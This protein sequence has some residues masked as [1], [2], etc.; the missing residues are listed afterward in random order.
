MHYLSFYCTPKRT[1]LITS[2]KRF[3]LMKRSGMF[4]SI[5]LFLTVSLPSRADIPLVHLSS[6][7]GLSNNSVWCCLQDR[8]GFM[9]FGTRDGLDRYDGTDFKL[10]RK[11]PDDSLSLGNNFVKSLF[12]PSFEEDIWVGTDDGVYIFDYN[13]ET[14][15]R[16]SSEEA[17]YGPIYDMTEDKNGNV[18]ISAYG[19][20]LYR[21]ERSSGS[22]RKYSDTVSLN[23]TWRLVCDD[24]GTVWGCTSSGTLN[25]YDQSA[26]DFQILYP[27][28]KELTFSSIFHDAY[29]SCLWLGTAQDGLW[30][31]DI[32]SGSWLKVMGGFEGKALKNI[33]DILQYDSNSFLIGCDNGLLILGRDGSCSSLDCKKYTSPDNASIFSLLKDSEGGLWIGTYYYGILYLRPNYKAVEWFP[34]VGGQGGANSIVSCFARHDDNSVWVG[35]NNFGLLL[36]DPI[37][38][39]VKTA[40]IQ[41]KSANIKSLLDDGSN[42]WIGYYNDGLQRFSYSHGNY[43]L[44]ESFTHTESDSLSIADNAVYSLFKGRDGSLYIGSQRGLQVFDRNTRSFVRQN[45][46]KD[47]R[48][49][50]ITEDSAGIIWIASYGEG[51]IGYNPGSGKTEVYS[52]ADGLPSNQLTQVSVDGENNVWCGTTG[53]LAKL[54]RLEKKIRSFGGLSN[55]SV[56]AALTDEGGNVWISGDHGID[57]LEKDSGNVKSYTVGDGLGS[58]QFCESAAFPISPS[59][60]LFGCTNGFNVID[61]KLLGEPNQVEPKLFLGGMVP[62]GGKDELILACD[63]GKVQF[64]AGVLSYYSPSQNHCSYMLEGED[65]GRTWEA[66]HNVQPATWKILSANQ[67]IQ[68]GRHAFSQ[69]ETAAYHCTSAPIGVMAD[70]PTVHTLCRSP[71][72]MA[73]VPYKASRPFRS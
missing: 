68:R 53:G 65:N 27:D 49:Y 29:T 45:W 57:R 52:S 35:T 26:D 62:L 39:K 17:P 31:Y 22:M 33:H 73:A 51:L 15:K 18:W 72:G 56:S 71:G 12:Q 34:A 50:D 32:D 13:N 20:G 3:S 1:I 21:Y 16:L 23:W 28:A 55:A 6:S 2:R 69:S 61:S 67:G 36:Y 5:V 60:F 48:I 58:G 24:S 44:E 63:E 14:F 7:E 54:D 38:E 64:E 66:S 4:L 19:N 25:R 40:G 10:Y 41:T 47:C 9:W 70:D 42:L 8:A 30:R 46:V 37:Q 11:A 59:K 43:R